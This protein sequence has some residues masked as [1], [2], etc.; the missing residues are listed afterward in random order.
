MVLGCAGA[1]KT[2]WKRD[3]WDRLRHLYF[4]H[5]SFAGGVG[6]WNTEAAKAMARRYID[7]EI[8]A[9]ATST[10]TPSC[11]SSTAASSPS[12]PHR[13]PPGSPRPRCHR[14]RRGGVRSWATARR[15][16]A[17][18]V[19]PNTRRAYTE[20]SADS[21]PSGSRTRPSSATSPRSA[22]R[23]KAPSKRV[24][25]GGRGAL[26]SRAGKSAA[27]RGPEGSGR[28]RLAG[29]PSP[30][31]E[32]T[33]RA[34]AGHRRTW[35]RSARPAT[36]RDVS[37]AASKSGKVTFRRGQLDS[38]IAGLLC[39]AEMRRSDRSVLPLGAGTQSLVTRRRHRASAGPRSTP[40]SPAPRASTR[41]G[42]GGRTS[43]SR[44]GRR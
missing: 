1:G 14:S 12:Q 21:T 19:S 33:P 27:I 20:A 4:D 5:D 10:A 8:A 2:A 23:D 43:S 29:S 18:S 24:D 40:P 36:G 42:H 39:M 7:E 28:A 34:F 6:D 32:R 25:G 22:S 26:L 41:L 38:M 13:Y 16:V 9:K 15:L 3:N 31:A 44:T 17:A 11:R 37:A 35:P 30:V